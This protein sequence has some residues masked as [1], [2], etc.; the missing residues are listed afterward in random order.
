MGKKLELSERDF[1]DKAMSITTKDSAVA[2]LMLYSSY[3]ASENNISL[4]EALD[5]AKS[6]IAYYTGYVNP[7]TREIVEELFD[8]EHPIFGKIKENGNPTSKECFYC[9]YHN[10]TLNV[11]RK[12]KYKYDEKYENDKK[13]KS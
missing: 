7:N 13:N 6:N 2:L 8:C 5:I 1:L 9:G 10:I 11:Y 4:K 3:I 12:D